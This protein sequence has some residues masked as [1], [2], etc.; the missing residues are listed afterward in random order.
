MANIFGIAV[1]FVAVATAFV[2]PTTTTIST[3]EHAWR[4]SWHGR[5]PAPAARARSAPPAA[6]A[7]A[8]GET[9]AVASAGAASARTSAA[10]LRA[11]GGRRAGRGSSYREGTGLR[12][13]ADAAS[14]A[15]PTVVVTGLGVVS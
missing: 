5:A 8:S 7:W 15:R 2:P 9:A 12:M 13:M 14:G 6:G 3:H 11:A 1:S 10:T 4:H